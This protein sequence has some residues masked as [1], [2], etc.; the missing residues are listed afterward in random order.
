MR[1]IL[2]LLAA[3]PVL[4]QNRV[5]RD[6]DFST[7]WTAQ[8]IGR[9]EG[10]ANARLTR[11]PAGGRDGAWG[12]V[13]ISLVTSSPGY[14]YSPGYYYGEPAPTTPGTAWF[15]FTRPDFTIPA[16]EFARLESFRATE[17]FLHVSHSCFTCTD[18]VTYYIAI[19]QGSSTF[20]AARRDWTPTT[21]WIRHSLTNLR[22]ADFVEFGTNLGNRLN[23]TPTGAPL[24]IGIVRG[25]EAN[26]S[27]E[28]VTG[29]D[30]FIFQ[31]LYTPLPPDISAVDD[32][33]N[34]GAT[35]PATF[36]VP[37]EE[38]VLANDEPYENRRAAIVTPPRGTV[39]LRPDGSFTYTPPPTGD[40]DTFTYRFTAD[41]GTS[42]TAVARINLIRDASLSC[43]IKV[44]PYR[45]YSEGITYYRDVPGAFRILFTPWK[46]NLPFTISILGEG[47]QTL[48]APRQFSTP[49]GFINHL[50]IP[51]F[52]ATGA[53]VAKLEVTGTATNCTTSIPT[54]E[55]F[56]TESKQPSD[57]SC[58]LTSLFAY[59]SG[60]GVP[61]LNFL[62]GLRNSRMPNHPTLSRWRELY[63]RFSPE[64][65]ALFAKQPSLITTAADILKEVGPDKPL[66]PSLLAHAGDYARELLPLAS[67]ALRA[68][69]EQFLKDIDRP[70]IHAAIGVSTE[71]VT[72]STKD[73]QGNT[74]L[75]GGNGRDAFVRK[76]DSTGKLLFSRTFG[77]ASEDMAL[78]LAVMPSG[79]IAITGFTNSTNFPVLTP[80]QANNG[81]ATDAFLT[82]VDPR[83]GATVLSTYLGGSLRDFARG[84]AVDRTNNIYIAGVT[85]S[86]NFP[87]LNPIQASLRGTE[88]G[89][90][91]KFNPTTRALLWSTFYGGNSS[92]AIAQI[93]L[94]TDTSVVFT[95]VT[96]SVRQFPLVNATQPNMAGMVDAFLA[97]INPTGTALTF[98]TYY[99]GDSADTA[100]SITIAPNGE[101]V[102]S[103]I[104]QNITGEAGWLARF[105]ANGT[106]LAS[107]LLSGMPVDLVSIGNNLELTGFRTTENFRLEPYIATQPA[108]LTQ[109]AI[110]LPIPVAGPA[111]ATA[112][113]TG[114]TIHGILLD[115][116]LAG[117]TL[118]VPDSTLR[119][120]YATTRSI[121]A[122]I[123]PGALMVLSG[124]NLPALTP[125]QA[126]DGANPPI[127]LANLQLRLG[128]DILAP[129]HAASPTELIFVV[130][131]DVPAGLTTLTLLEGDKTIAALTTLIEPAVP[132]LFSHLGQL[133]TGEDTRL[134]LVA[135]GLG[136]ATL[137]YSVEVL[138]GTSIISIPVATREPI[139]G[140]LGL[141]QILTASLPPDLL[142]A[143]LLYLRVRGADSAS[144]I[145]TFT[146][147]V[148]P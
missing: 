61:D 36:S 45:V 16:S 73:A 142:K 23:L 95:G 11:S 101:L 117:F 27:T 113:T 49:P 3:L 112:R 82:I 4:S 22:L 132:Q 144:A 81:G 126:S 66:T 29:I 39:A 76:L 120:R 40:T 17:S 114:N 70:D 26:T 10:T 2:L 18:S 8:R 107:T 33:Y 54:P 9:Q 52:S 122:T 5:F 129:L 28:I 118:T 96:N 121:A 100:T 140:Y 69:L 31:P 92:D 58:A 134:S 130:P 53:K 71:M 50:D 89:F 104:S 106:P 128:T 116:P 32:T 94:D 7:A 115:D 133:V 124:F 35:S 108:D 146:M 64:L 85:Q 97:R 24:Q 84:I 38:G 90:V 111:I 145:A 12:I 131:A 119:L 88:D 57:G 78:G 62:R 13:T 137:E 125:T 110:A 63:Y 87:T 136:A 21:G 102:V 48:G 103:G 55:P 19:R 30:D 44:E 1:L 46:T 147:P 51:F 127:T 75:V 99:G 138:T 34:M 59:L 42:S 86:T 80:L 67:P 15:F 79:N 47:G 109:P 135:S 123:A 25:F 14:S 37:A 56:A 98:S 143:S 20:V 77:G 65:I 91:L 139:A 148:A 141:E 74:W 41:A 43:T 105:R 72:A 6:E 93:A 83:E 60:H 68:E